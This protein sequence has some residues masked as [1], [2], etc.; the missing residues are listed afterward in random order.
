M[1]DVRRMHACKA[2]HFSTAALLHGRADLEGQSSWGLG[3]NRGVHRIG[4]LRGIYMPTRVLQ[5]NFS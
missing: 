5:L 3:W 1:H 2:I 4:T